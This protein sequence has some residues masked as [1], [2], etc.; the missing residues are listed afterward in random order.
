MSY[1]DVLCLP[2]TVKPKERNRRIKLGT[3]PNTQ[4]A[5]VLLVQA[6]APANTSIAPAHSGIIQASAGNLRT[7]PRAKPSCLTCL[8]TCAPS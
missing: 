1:P 7:T 3:S 4:R 5:V 2:G 8:G 6:T